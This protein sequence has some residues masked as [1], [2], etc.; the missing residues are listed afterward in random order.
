MSSPGRDCVPVAV[1]AGGPGGG[2]AGRDGGDRSS[3]AEPNAAQAGDLA[4]D[5]RHLA[6][7]FRVV[8]VAEEGMPQATRQSAKVRARRDALGA[9]LLR[10]APCGPSRRTYE[11]VLD[12][13]R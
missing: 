4:I 8:A 11:F 1:D 13:D 5:R 3:A 2:G 7:N 12:P 9:E 6:R 10:K